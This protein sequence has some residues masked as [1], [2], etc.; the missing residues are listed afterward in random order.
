MGKYYVTTPIY[1]PSD[2]LH[3][4][5]AYTT[6]AAD[7]L[8][9]FH[10]LLGDEVYFLTGSDEHG[11]K[12]Q[13]IA[14]SKGIQPK[15]Y[16]DRIVATFQDL[17]RRLDIQY[18]DFIR[19]TE[20]RHQRAVQAIFKRL[21]DQG[22]IYKSKY[23]GWYC[24]PCEAFWLERQLEDGKCPDCHRPVQWVEEESYFLRLSAYQDRLLQH[25]QAHPEFIQPE[26]RR[27][28]MIRFIEAGLNDLS[29]SRT[30]FDWGIP[31]PGDEKHVVY[32]WIDALSNYITALGYASADDHLYR[33]FWPAD[34]HL[35][36]KEIVRFHTIIWPIILMALGLPLPK[37]VFGHGWLLFDA[38][39]MSKSRGNVVDPV[40]LI[41]EFGPD[42]LRYFL[43]REVVF[44]QDGNFSREALIHRTNADLAN[45]LGNLL[46]RS[47][48]MLERYRDGR[49]PA[50]GPASARD[51]ELMGLVGEVKRETIACMERLEPH[52]ALASI[53]RLIGRANKYID[54]EAPWALQ[55]Q[56]QQERLD[57]VLYN[58]VEVLRNVAI[59]VWPFIPRTGQA[60]WQR[61]GLPGEILQQGLAAVK[62]GLYPPGGA[63]TRGEPLFPRI[64]EKENQEKG[65]PYVTMDQAVFEK[66]AA[67]AGTAP[68]AAATVPAA[69][70][71]PEGAAAPSPS[72]E[73]APDGAPLPQ[74]TIDEFARLDLRL[75]TIEEAEA[76][77]KADKLLR[78]QVRMGPERR[79]IVAGIAR[80]YR[81]EELVG[82]QI[83]VVAN[84]KPAR[85]RGV[86][87][88][89]MLLA[90][91][92]PDGEQLAI[93][94]PDKPLPAGCK[95]K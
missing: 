59:L 42:P 6:T 14:A 63:V 1:Y 66:P 54:E 81:P 34:L 48:S 35:V 32:V 45:D 53:W 15:E 82:R 43:L 10:K 16:V 90:A 57:T 46:Y 7:A 68:G 22:D 74:I 30:T 17:W 49:V 77:P 36:G 60:I 72:A 27:N 78:L 28:E 3:V 61:L 37:Q 11:Q 31:V 93:L 38:E 4:G 55:R 56:G 92:T 85:L 94:G 52:N 70:A 13:R 95:V 73:P 8:A 69:G 71:A 88:Q 47:A 21:L 62:W 20:P 23:E 12:I 58:L 91:S 80:H 5:H 33:K 86:E 83:V 39:K 44:G 2:K 40:A 76:I 64:E 18:D 29:V 65:E 89:G 75:A 9:R 84:L 19:T 50:P 41:E 26:S 25:I 79:Q 67:A 87:S 51:R 24:E